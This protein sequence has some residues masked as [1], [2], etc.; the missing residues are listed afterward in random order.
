MT[1]GEQENDKSHGELATF[2]GSTT[3]HGIRYSCDDSPL[4]RRVFWVVVVVCSV[5][6][7]AF[8]ISMSLMTYYEFNTVTSTTTSSANDELRFP[9]LTLCNNNKVHR[10]RLNLLYPDIADLWRHAEYVL[11]G[12]EAPREDFNATLLEDTVFSD[13]MLASGL[14]KEE[15]FRNCMFES[16]TL[17]CTNFISDYHAGRGRCF[18]FHS[19]QV[20]GS[21]AP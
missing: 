10:T 12:A 9:T 20:R 15:T 18:S 1:E 5:V 21:T 3:L 6:F 13:A 14:V 7:C 17:N 8:Q 11:A 2:I 16:D 19:S 4:A